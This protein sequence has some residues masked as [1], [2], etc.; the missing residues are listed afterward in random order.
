MEESWRKGEHVFT[1][2]Q[3]DLRGD[4]L[5][6]FMLIQA[7]PLQPCSVFRQNAVP[8]TTTDQPAAPYPHTLTCMVITPRTDETCNGVEGGVF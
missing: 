2:V 4:L 3:S 1:L 8:P 5:E 7:D 6:V